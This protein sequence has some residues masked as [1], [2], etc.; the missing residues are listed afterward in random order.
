M[1]KLNLYPRRYRRDHAYTCNTS[2]SVCLCLSVRPSV[3][4]S[5]CLSVCLCL[6]VCLY[7][8]NCN[9]TTLCYKICT[10]GVITQ[11]SISDT[12]WLQ[13]TLPIRLGGLGF[14]ETLTSSSA[15]FL[16]SCHSSRQIIVRLLHP[17]HHPQ[18][19]EFLVKGLPAVVL[20]IISAMKISQ[21]IRTLQAILRN[22]FRLK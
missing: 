3:R 21:I 8:S 19:S 22:H 20:T 18:P 16:G 12:F 9:T 10:L 5:V 11:S 17:L 6:Y 1:F 7:V 15:A 14:R 4:L 13:A 2:D